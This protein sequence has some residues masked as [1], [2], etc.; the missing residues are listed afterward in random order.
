MKKTLI[1]LLWA[2]FLCQSSF[3]Q[4][5]LWFDEQFNDNQRAWWTGS[6]ENSRASI[7]NGTYTA[8]IL[9]QNAGRYGFW[10]S[11]F[12]LDY[13]RD[14]TVEATLTHKAGVIDNGYGINIGVADIN[15]LLSFGVSGNGHFRIVHYATGKTQTIQAWLKH[16]AIKPNGSAN[17]LKIKHAAG[18]Y[19]FLINDREVAKTTA[20]LLTGGQVGVETNGQ[21]QVEAADFRI[22]QHNTINLAPNVPKIIRKRDLGGNVNSEYAE[23]L[24]YISPDGKTLYFSIHGHPENTGGVTDTDEVW[25]STAA[26]D[27]LWGKRQNM[28]RPINNNLPNAVIAVTPDNNR[29]LLMNQYTAQGESAGSGISMAYR[30]A[31]GWAV[32]INV[33]IEDFYNRSPYNEY[34]LAADGKTLYM[35]LKRDDT[36]GEKD[37]YVC[38]L[39]NDSTWTAPK[40]LGPGIN[41]FANDETPFIAADGVTLYYSTGGRAG[42]GSNDIYITRRLDDT[43]QNW[44]EPQNLGDQINTPGWDAYYTIPASGAYAFM[45]SSQNGAALNIVQLKLPEALKPKPVVLVYGKVLD[46]KTKQ[47]LQADIS[48]RNLV[49]NQEVG[50][51]NSSPVDG[52]YKIV[53]PAGQL[54]GFLARKAGYVAISENLDLK[55]LAA[56]REVER[57]LYLTPLEMGQVIRLNNVFFDSNK[58]ELRA[59][60]KAELERLTE[61]LSQNPGMRIELSGHTDNVGADESNRMLSQNRAESVRNRLVQNGATANLI[62]AKGY[63]ETKPRATNN[64]EEGRQ[65]NRCVEFTILDAGSAAK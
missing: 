30:T 13:G 12:Y 46:T 53:L 1:L 25:F 34:S 49:S 16:E 8:E 18:T 62:V 6:N 42:Y 14:F 61:I 38:F 56:Y 36:K 3:S 65:M 29:M 10:P 39:K 27:T 17:A 63:G 5:M 37:I 50:I 43:W 35:S 60:S 40:N 11:S 21:M 44:S 51:A 64:T 15:N 23:K 31:K 52:S 26:N 9:Q 19:T 4:A 22:W 47:P 28:G 58:S 57:N 20:P 59:E 48:Y 7:A 45:C 55:Q 41:T 2:F 32:P 33:K 54:Y 24:P